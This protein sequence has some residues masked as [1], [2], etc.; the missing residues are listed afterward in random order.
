MASTYIK[1]DLS[2]SETIYKYTWSAWI[3]RTGLGVAGDLFKSRTDSNNWVQAYLET[4]N[5]FILQS[6]KNGGYHYNYK[7]NREF[8]DVNGWYHFVLNVDSSQS[9]AGDRVRIY[10]NGERLTS[11]ATSTNNLSNGDSLIFNTSDS[12]TG[13]TIGSW[14]AGTY[15]NGLMSHVHYSSG[16]SYAPTVFGSTDSTTGE[17]KIITSPTFTLGGN[18]YT[19]LKDGNTITD[20][21][22]NSND[23][24]LGGGT[25][26]KTE[27]NPSNVFSTWNPLHKGNNTLAY[28]TGNTG[29]SSSSN[30][31]YSTTGTLGFSSGKFYFEIK[32]WGDYCQIGICD[33]S[34]NINAQD[35]QDATGTTVFYN[36]DGGEMRKDGVMTTAN[37][38]TFNSTD[39][40][41]FAIDMDNKTMSVY[42]NGS[43]IVSN[44]AI[45]TS[46]ETALPYV[47]N[48]SSGNL[49]YANF[50]NGYFGTTAVSSAGTNASNNGI[51]EYDVPTGYT[52][53]STKGL[54]L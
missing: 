14:N 13:H 47:S 45:S 40:A 17:W 19:V 9:T 1:R 38:G 12:G 52:A 49:I 20:Q 33:T 8:R 24:T 50:G 35:S 28:S 4:D 25:L 27:D 23:F 11:F 16:Y 53:L 41:G 46:I 7:T 26:T 42:K 43:A 44:Y 36:Y 5:K 37:Y 18:G 48:Y 6:Y 30:A 31:W 2:V 34:V 32:D 15:F 22:S 29:V 3:K 39:I 10:V 54:N 51:F 21:S